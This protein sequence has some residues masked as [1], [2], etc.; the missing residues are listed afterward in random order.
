MH[1]FANAVGMVLLGLTLVGLSPFI[2][3]GLCVFGVAEMA[4]WADLHGPFK[5]DVSA[6]DRADWRMR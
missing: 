1:Y 6:R 5:G 4:R 2:L 3:L